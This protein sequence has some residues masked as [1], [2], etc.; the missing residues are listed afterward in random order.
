MVAKNG[1]CAL[2]KQDRLSSFFA[3]FVCILIDAFYFG[4]LAPAAKVGVKIRFCS[5]V[6]IPAGFRSLLASARHI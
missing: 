4:I 5:I 3:Q 6:I 2:S 1:D